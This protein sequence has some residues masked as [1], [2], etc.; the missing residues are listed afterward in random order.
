MLPLPDKSIVIGEWVEKFEEV[1]DGHSYIV[2]S[3]SDGIVFKKLYNKIGERGT[4]LL[5]STNLAYEPYEI[6]V[7]DIREIWRFTA[8]ISRDFPEEYDPADHLKQAFERIEHE[9]Q[10]LKM[11]Q[12]A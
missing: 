1:R 10:D 2:V 3:D 12:E 6:P 5:K 7:S 8:F 4:I 11:H 9:I